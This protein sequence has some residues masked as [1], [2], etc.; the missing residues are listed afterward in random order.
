VWCTNREG[1]GRWVPESYLDRTGDIAT[2]RCDYS[3]VELTVTTGEELVLEKEAGDW[4][5][6]T[7]QA[8]YSGWVPAEH[9]KIEALRG[10]GG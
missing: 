4:Y 1:E 2:A 8:G 9:V 5:W 10:P 3:A 6:A 7:N